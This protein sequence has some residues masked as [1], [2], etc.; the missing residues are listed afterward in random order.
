MIFT[1][2]N[3]HIYYVRN[4]ILNTIYLKTIGVVFQELPKSSLQKPCAYFYPII[5]VLLN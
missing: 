4:V 3:D 5:N 2:I 1:H